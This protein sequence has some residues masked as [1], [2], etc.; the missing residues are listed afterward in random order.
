V[1]LG[2]E[3]EDRFVHLIAHEYI[4]VQQAAEQPNP[5]VLECAL[6]EG[7]AGF[8]GELISGGISNIAVHR[9]ARGREL[10]IEKRFAAALDKTDLSAWF[11]NTTTEDVG[12]FG[13]WVGCRLRR[14]IFRMRRIHRRPFATSCT[15]K[16]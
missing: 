2:A 14:H 4:H 3:I 5:T 11:D 13:Y 1:D 7:V 6:Q 9:A 10:E 15:Q 8:L 12:Q 16:S